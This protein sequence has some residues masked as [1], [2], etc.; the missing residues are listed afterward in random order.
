VCKNW[1]LSPAGKESNYKRHVK[2]SKTEK[3]KISQKRRSGRQ[4]IKDRQNPQKV[5]NNAMATAIYLSLRKNKKRRHWEDL[6][7]YKLED[8][9]EHLEKRFDDK[10]NWSNY[11][12]Y[13]H[14]DH[15]KPKSKF[16]YSHPEELEFKKCW[17]LENLQPLEGKENI[18]KSNKY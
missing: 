7:G 12:T 3:G 9:K 5:L 15:I 1:F 17:S 16:K 8:L 4:Y 6:V 14:I 11:G 10:M 2:Y 13:W 18:R